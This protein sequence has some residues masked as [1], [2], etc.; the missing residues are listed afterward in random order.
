M[1]PSMTN[2][3]LGQSCADTRGRNGLHDG[4]AWL[5]SKDAHELVLVPIERMVSKVPMFVELK[6]H[7]PCSTMNSPL[8]EDGSAYYNM[9]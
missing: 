6:S 5:F 1:T 8:Y 2:V 9:P 7:T 3:Q 4:G